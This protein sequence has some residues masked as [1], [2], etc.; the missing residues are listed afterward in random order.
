MVGREAAFSG[1]L[2]IGADQ[3]KRPLQRENEL[4]TTPNILAAEISVYGIKGRDSSLILVVTGFILN[5]QKTRSQSTDDGFRSAP[6]FS[7]FD[8]DL[9][10]GEDNKA[11]NLNREFTALQI[12]AFGDR[13]QGFHRT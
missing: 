12:Q 4:T 2:I 13:Q 1:S 6:G 9:I 3:R 11:K 7:R 10:Q 8:S 5:L